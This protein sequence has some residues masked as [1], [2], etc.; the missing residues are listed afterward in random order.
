MKRILFFSILLALILVS[1]TSAQEP[2]PKAPENRTAWFDTCKYLFPGGDVK[3]GLPVRTPD[4]EFPESARRQKL[5]SGQ[6]MVAVALN[7]QGT[8]DDVKIVSSSNPAFAQSSVAAVKQWTFK[9][10]MKDG[11]PV[12]VQFEVETNFRSY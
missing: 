9:P 5:K 12:A 11:S 6:A 4:P 7:A 8:V 1:I 3:Q 2:C 10:A